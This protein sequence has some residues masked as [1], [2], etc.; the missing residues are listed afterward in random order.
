M[1]LLVLEWQAFCQQNNIISQLQ[2]IKTN[3]LKK[4]N[5]R[6]SFKF[7][8]ADFSENGQKIKVVLKIASNKTRITMDTDESYSLEIKDLGK[9]VEIKAQTYFGARHGLETLSQLISYDELRQKLQMHT[10]AMVEDQPAYIHRGLLIDTSRN[11]F[12]F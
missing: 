3:S 7:F 5:E 9:A 10:K 2:Q 1:P 8:A 6:V 4:Q 11:F 12:R